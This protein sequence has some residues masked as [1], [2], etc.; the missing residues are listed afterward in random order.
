MFYLGYDLDKPMETIIEEFNKCNLLCR[1]CHV[2]KLKEIKNMAVVIIRIH[3]QWN[4]E[5]WENIQRE[6][7]DAINVKKQRSYTGKS[8]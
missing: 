6:N 1:K 5:Q 8:R 3:R 2:E 7:A 4:V